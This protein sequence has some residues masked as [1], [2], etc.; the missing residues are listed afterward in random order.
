[1]PFLIFLYERRGITGYE[2]H[3]NEWG[4]EWRLNIEECQ[5]FARST[6]HLLAR[7]Y[8]CSLNHT[9]ARSTISCTESCAVPSQNY[10]NEWWLKL[11]SMTTVWCGPECCYCRIGTKL[12]SVNN[13]P[14]QSD[15][16]SLGFLVSNHSWLIIHSLMLWNLK[17]VNLINMPQQMWSLVGLYPTDAGSPSITR[18]VITISE[19]R[20]DHYLW[21][22][23]WCSKREQYNLSL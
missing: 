1:M 23:N 16:E 21:L 20:C 8:I 10:E 17:C 18:Q 5:Q 9:F 19:L 6:I 14:R 2:V 13:L 22:C 4:N 15:M 3:R 12:L 7:L 11:F